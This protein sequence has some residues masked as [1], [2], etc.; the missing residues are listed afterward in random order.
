M[1]KKLQGLLESKGGGVMNDVWNRIFKEWISCYNS[2]EQLSSSG[3]IDEEEESEL[4][5][6]LLDE[7]IETMRS[8]VE[9]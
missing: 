3:I 9:E 8:E 1:Q 2:I 5:I 4:Q 7:L 6:K